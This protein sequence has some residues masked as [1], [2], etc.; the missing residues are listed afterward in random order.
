MSGLLLFER[1]PHRLFLAH[2]MSCTSYDWAPDSS[3]S[4]RLDIST[5]RTCPKGAA[6]SN[7]GICTTAAACSPAATASFTL[8]RYS[9][10][11]GTLNRPG[12]VGGGDPSNPGWLTQ[13]Q[14]DTITRL[15]R[16]HRP[17]L[18]TQP[19]PPTTATYPAARPL[20]HATV[21]PRRARPQRRTRRVTRP[22]TT[23]PLTPPATYVCSPQ[24]RTSSTCPRQRSAKD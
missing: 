1:H 24:T 6:A 12:K 8:C 13:P 4:S 17:W 19:E 18:A 16:G 10:A 15:P 14:T 9:T 5:S 22:K 21:R 23:A 7:A 11:S 2:V 3:S 20:A